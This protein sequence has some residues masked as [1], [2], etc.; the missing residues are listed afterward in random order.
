MALLNSGTPTTTLSLTAG[1]AYAFG[2]SGIF[3]GGVLQ[4]ESNLPSSTS[5]FQTVKEL[6]AGDMFE[7]IAA[8][9]GLRCTLRAPLGTGAAVNVEATLRT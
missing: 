9:P 8:G 1:K 6:M 2:A 5:E 7:Y 3:A 4:L